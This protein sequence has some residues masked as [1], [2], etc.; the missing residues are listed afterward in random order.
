[1]WENLSARGG[2]G[3]PLSESRGERWIGGQGT[4]AL[5]LT[6]EHCVALTF[7]YSMKWAG[8]ALSR[9]YE[10]VMSTA[11]SWHQASCQAD[12]NYSGDT[13]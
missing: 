3:R 6:D 2:E 11:A 1:M 10:S 12:S 9:P 7:P 13:G 4:W 5:V 8:P